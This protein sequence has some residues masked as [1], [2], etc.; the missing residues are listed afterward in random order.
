MCGYFSVWPAYWL[1]YAEFRDDLRTKFVLPG[2]LGLGDSQ[3]PQFS[4]AGSVVSCWSFPEEAE[5]SSYPMAA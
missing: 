4:S 1:H 2:F 5:T 3:R